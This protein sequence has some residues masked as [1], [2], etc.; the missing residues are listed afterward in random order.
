M[1]SVETQGLGRLIEDGVIDEVVGQ[2]KTG[3]E[4]E[5][6]L[7]QRAG[8]IIAAK[9]Y[10]DRSQRSFKTRSGYQEG[11]QVRNSRT[12]RAIDKGSRFGQ[13]AEEDAWKSTEADALFKLHALGVRVP[14]PVLFYEGVLLMEAVIDPEGFPAPRLIEAPISR[15]NALAMYLD[16]RREIIKM[17]CADVIHGD[18]SPFNILLAWN[19]PTL[20]DFPQV[21]SAAGNNRA[22]MFFKRDLDN[23]RN[24]FIGIDPAVRQHDSDSHAIWNAYQRRDLTP[25]FEPPTRALQPHD[26]TV[27]GR[28]GSSPPGG[29]IVMRKGDPFVPG[30][31]QVP[32]Q[33]PARNQTGG[34]G[35]KFAGSPRRQGGN[36]SRPGG[37]GGPRTGG[38][39]PR[40]SNGGPPRQ[41]GSGS[42]RQGEGAARPPGAGG[43][44]HRRFAEGKGRSDVPQD[45]PQRSFRGNRS[46]R[47]RR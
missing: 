42:P 4:A 31:A 41:F 43:N 10:K 22:E 8:E 39:A 27:S 33:D 24:F 25:Q 44:G 17:L 34:D 40:Q 7:V 6:H 47:G 5:V 20:I 36:S 13:N 37:G 21:V 45:R 32:S 15:A 14:Q 12:Q 2:L 23:L 9:V 16:L 26:L 11:R 1:R 30:E 46:R 3:K 38:G 18:L 29:P 35:S 19:G 28:R